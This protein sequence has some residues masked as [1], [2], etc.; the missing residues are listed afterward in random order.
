MLTH[1]AITQQKV[2][3]FNFTLFCQGSIVSLKQTKQ[4]KFYYTAVEYFKEIMSTTLQENVFFLN[5]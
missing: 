1:H 2:T 3:Y 4:K 5:S